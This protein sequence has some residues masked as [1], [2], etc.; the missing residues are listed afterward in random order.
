MDKS[1]KEKIR[2]LESYQ[3]ELNNLIL[4]IL[5]YYENNLI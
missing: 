4:D 3:R 5:D 1:E 2:G